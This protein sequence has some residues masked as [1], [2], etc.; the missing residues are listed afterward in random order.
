MHDETFVGQSETLEQIQKYF[1]QVNGDTAQS[2][3]S[4]SNVIS[5]DKQSY[6]APVKTESVNNIVSDGTQLD[7]TANLKKYLSQELHMQEH[8]IDEDTQFIDLGLDSITGVTWVR[9]INEKYSLS[10]EATKV[11]SY[12]TLT[13]FSQFIKAEIS[14]QVASSNKIEVDKI[15]TTVN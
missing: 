8:E 7:L 2:S 9:K 4:D 12:P 14:K 13:Q 11:Y 6:S 1:M 3:H 15:A 5:N 10:I